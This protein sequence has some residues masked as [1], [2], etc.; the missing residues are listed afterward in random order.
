MAKF[1]FVGEQ[2]S[3]RAKLLGVTWREGRLDLEKTIKRMSD[4][5]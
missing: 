5:N 3:G 2:R 4:N 1:V